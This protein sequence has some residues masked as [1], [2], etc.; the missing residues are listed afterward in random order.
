MQHSDRFFGDRFF[1][2]SLERRCLNG[3]VMLFQKFD[4][5]QDTD[6]SLLSFS[7]FQSYFPDARIHAALFVLALLV[8]Q[9]IFYIRLLLFS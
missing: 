2:E 3:K 7:T 4:V 1:E 9:I 6:R 5:T 8:G